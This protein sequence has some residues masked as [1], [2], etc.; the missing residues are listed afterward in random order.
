MITAFLISLIAFIAYIA[1]NAFKHG[2]TASISDTYYLNTGGLGQI[3]FWAWAL[4]TAF[5]LMIYWLEITD[6]QT[7]QFLVFLSTA[8]LIFVG[9]AGA[10]KE[11]L[12]DKVHMYS[13]IA[14]FILSHVWLAVYCTPMLLFC[15]LT[16]AVFMSIGYNTEVTNSSGNKVKA[17]LY[18]AELACF[19]NIYASVIAYAML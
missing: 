9:T 10:F 7:F 13:A 4:L 6:G 8:S 5:P 15:L 12:T 11:S 1:Y 16:F 18:F 3:L 14:A 17:T 19:I 2:I